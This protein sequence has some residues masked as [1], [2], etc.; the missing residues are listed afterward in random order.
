M[1][2]LDLTELEA[3]V[4]WLIV[5]RSNPVALPEA[6]RESE[7]TLFAKVYRAYRGMP[8]EKVA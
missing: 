4:A 6:L 1:P 8:P 5:D 2:T 3:K 7:R